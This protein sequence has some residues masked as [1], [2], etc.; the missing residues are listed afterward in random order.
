[1]KTTCE[2]EFAKFKS[3]T[4]LAPCLQMQQMVHKM[5]ATLNFFFNAP[6]A[7]QKVQS[8]VMNAKTLSKFGCRLDIFTLAHYSIFPS[9]PKGEPPSL[10]LEEKAWVL[11]AGVRAHFLAD[12][13]GYTRELGEAP[14]CI[15]SH[16][17][18]NGSDEKIVKCIA[19][20]LANYIKPLRLIGNR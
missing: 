15:R 9:K 3:R 14:S 1:M 7:P 13:C 16:E 11:V 19:K 5:R 8:I 4:R 20:R 6:F 17:I 10:L 2:I 12:T 18:F